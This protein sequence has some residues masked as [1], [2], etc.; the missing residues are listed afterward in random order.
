MAESTW[1]KLIGKQLAVNG[2]SWEDVVSSTL[3]E[4][5]MDVEFCWDEYGVQGRS[6]T[7]WTVNRVYFP[8]NYD[9]GEWV[10]SVA[11]NPDGKATQHVGNS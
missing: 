7:L 9:C 11:R 6:F 8:A 4:E 10:D 1:R 2:E 3:S 5:E